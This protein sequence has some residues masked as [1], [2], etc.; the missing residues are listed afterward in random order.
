MKHGEL[1]KINT[2]S[3]PGIV[4]KVGLVLDSELT[5]IFVVRSYD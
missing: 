5:I 4:D 2:T 1:V 3:I